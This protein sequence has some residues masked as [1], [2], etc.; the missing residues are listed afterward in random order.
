M[1]S[2][3][4]LVGIGAERSWPRRVDSGRLCW[5]GQSVWADGRGRRA[6]VDGTVGGTCAVQYST[7]QYC[8]VRDMG[9]SVQGSWRLLARFCGW[10]G[11]GQGTSRCQAN[12][13]RAASSSRCSAPVA[14]T[15]DI[16]TSHDAH[17]QSPAAVFFFADSHSSVAIRSSAHKCPFC[18]RTAWLPASPRQ[19]D[20]RNSHLVL[21]L[22]AAL[23]VKRLPSSRAPTAFTN[24]RLLFVPLHALWSLTCPITLRDPLSSPLRTSEPAR[25]PHLT[26]RE[27]PSDKAI[28]A[29]PP[30]PLPSPLFDHHLQLSAR[31]RAAAT[32]PEG[33]WTGA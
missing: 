2:S 26:S 8:P 7:V 12:V 23:S 13:V 4:D 9:R 33:C 16:T 15:T 22:S 11:H 27:N 32:A 29:P 28:P 20:S 10:D 18:E 19:C 17:P 31:G 1:C 21:S 5:N 14:T 30:A 25:Q 24:S 3:E 6:W